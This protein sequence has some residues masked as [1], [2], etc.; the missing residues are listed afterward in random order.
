MGKEPY[1]RAFFLEFVKNLG[2]FGFGL[3]VG[4]LLL[5]L[6]ASAQLYDA[7]YPPNH[8]CLILFEPEFTER[9]PAMGG[10]MT[11]EV[12]QR[13]SVRREYGTN[14]WRIE[15]PDLKW[16]SIPDRYVAFVICQPIEGE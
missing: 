11:V 1:W 13:G 14:Q 12:Y 8:R 16:S 9:F 3:F 5:A 2:F 7:P 6:P 15:H 10:H 4:S